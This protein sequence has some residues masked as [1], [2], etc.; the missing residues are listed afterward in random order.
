LTASGRTGS[1]S[2]LNLTLLEV[3]AALDGWGNFWRS[4][5]RELQATYNLSRER[6]KKNQTS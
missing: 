5:N 2:E 6:K 1:A 3:V 4:G